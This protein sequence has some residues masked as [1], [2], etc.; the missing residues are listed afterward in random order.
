MFWIGLI[1]GIILWQAIALIFGFLWQEDEDKFILGAT[2]LVGFCALGI[3]K[4]I[5][6]IKLYYRHTY[7]KAALVD[8]EEKLCYCESQDVSFYIED[9]L[10]SWAQG[11]RN[12]YKPE[13]GWR[14]Q[15]C[16]MDTVSLRYVPIKILKAEGAYCLPKVKEKS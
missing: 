6:R 3:F 12:K 1:V 9:G 10:Y 14:K 16:F 11:L 15:D 5:D 4:L 7:Y 2:G 8:A 13:D